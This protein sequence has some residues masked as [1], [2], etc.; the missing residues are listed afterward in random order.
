[1]RRLANVDKHPKTGIFRARKTYPDHL[2]KIL[3]RSGFTQSLGT[4]DPEVARK[5]AI[6]VLAELQKRIA[7]AQAVYDRGS[8]PPLPK[9]M[10]TIHEGLRAIQDW[11][12]QYLAGYLDDMNLN[13]R[14]RDPRKYPVAFAPT[15]EDEEELFGTDN[16]QAW[17][18]KLFKN[19]FDPNAMNWT[20]NRILREFGYELPDRHMVRTALLGPLTVML[21]AVKDTT[22]A[23]ERGEVDIASLPSERTFEH[24]GH[25]ASTK[26]PKTGR[27]SLDSMHTPVRLSELFEKYIAYTTAKSD[28]EQ[29]LAMRQFCDFLGNPNPFVNEI[30]RKHATEFYQVI[31][32]QPNSRTIA[33]SKLTLVQLAESIR[34]G[35][36][37]RKKIAGGTAAKKIQLLSAMFKYALETEMLCGGNPFVKIVGP[38]DAKPQTKRR[39]MTSE[40]LKA[41]FS[42]PVFSGCESYTKW[43]NSGDLLIANHRFWIP[44]L[45]M[46]TGCRI[47]EIGQLQIADIKRVDDILFFDITEE[48]EDEHEFNDGKK[49]LK[50]ETSVRRMPIHKIAVDAGFEKYWKWLSDKG[51]SQLF[52]ELQDEKRT[53]NMSRWFNRDFRPS[54]GIT[55]RRVVFHSF[56]HTFK[57]RCRDAQLQPELHH[58]L[59]GHSSR[60]VGDEYGDGFD[61]AMLKRG[62][63]ALT[64]PGFPNVPP[65][66]GK[67]VLTAGVGVALAATRP[68]LAQSPDL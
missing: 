4:R 41:I 33:D 20:L 64:F 28:V 48:I 62:I 57:D 24:A 63:D 46:L 65:R 44:L 40:Q 50:N 13:I 15:P 31:K 59:T 14:N 26:P 18:E 9:R 3:G 52:P 27:T 21:R 37:K 54:V 22:E 53:K 42:A 68:S 12:V 10:P 61:L 55:G 16:A 38:R 2:R 5:A 19:A 67:F 56:R 45:A 23:W 49:S 36:M 6:P 58:A 51:E 35:T 43:R 8:G 7:E 47:E 60:S 1:L 17:V 29:K 30:T 66:T 34:S 39:P 32:S 11:K 25:A